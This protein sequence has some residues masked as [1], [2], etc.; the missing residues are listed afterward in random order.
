MSFCLIVSVGALKAI[1]FKGGKD[2][3]TKIRSEII[4]VL[5]L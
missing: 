1:V 3:T 5:I 4:V 2:A